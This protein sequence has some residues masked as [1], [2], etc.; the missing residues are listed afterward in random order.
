[1]LSDNSW[2]ALNVGDKLCSPVFRIAEYIPPRPSLPKKIGG[3]EKAIGDFHSAT[4]DVASFLFH[5][6]RYGSIGVCMCVCVN[7]VRR[8]LE[9]YLAY[10]CC[11]WKGTCKLHVDTCFLLQYMHYIVC[12]LLYL[13]SYLFSYLAFFHL[14]LVPDFFSPIPNWNEFLQ[15]LFSLV[16]WGIALVDFFNSNI[17]AWC[18]W[19]SDKISNQDC[20]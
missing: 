16:Y 4:S 11:K 9:S 5:E 14:C 6:Y 15:K 3:A 12:K 20:R 2:C 13:F 1:M 18:R 7:L 10:M 17:L 8:V 19:V